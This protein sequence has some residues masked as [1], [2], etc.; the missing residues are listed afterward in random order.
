MKKLLSLLFVVVLLFTV[1]SC[2]INEKKDVK[3][4]TIIQLVTH[5]A[6]DKAT[7]GIIAGLEEAGFKDGENIKIKIVNPQASTDTLDLMAETAVNEADIIFCV[8][9]P[10]AQAAKAKAEAVASDVP[11][12]FTA[13]TDGVASGIIP[14]NEHPGGNI[15][16]TSDLNPVKEQIAILHEL[17]IDKVGFIYSSGEDNSKI[18]LNLAK[19]ACQDF[20]FDMEVQE[21]PVTNAAQDLDLTLNAIIDAG[22]K[23][24]YIP[25]DNV[26][27]SNMEHISDVLSAEGIITVG[28]EEG[29]V[30]SGATLTY[31]SVEYF[32]LGKV[33]GAMG[34]RVLNG[35]N[36]GDLAVQYSPSTDLYVNVSKIHEFNLPVSA[37]F[38]EKAT[39]TI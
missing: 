38:I 33:T 19:K 16:G 15:S 31:G 1:A 18:Q 5:P 14:S 35:T 20:E 10:A 27:A 9:T 36:A 32:S 24:V 11:I 12:L 37:E 23:A 30:D 39:K 4:V 13:V 3:N 28:G 8:A 26:M 7:E 22:L 2:T 21:F 17:N 34:A 25:T 29:L 6:L